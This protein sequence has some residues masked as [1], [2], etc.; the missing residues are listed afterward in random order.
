VELPD[1]ADERRRQLHEDLDALLDAERHDPGAALADVLVR[2]ERLQRSIDGHLLPTVAGFAGSTT[3]ALDGCRSPAAWFV[4]TLG[5][6]RAA[7]GSLRSTAEGA[8]AHPAIV[9]AARAGRVSLGHVRALLAARVAP[10]E[11][12]FDAAVQSLVE[13]AAVRSVDALVAHLERWRLDA[14]EELA[15][16]EPDGAPPEDPTGSTCRVRELLWGRAKVELDLDPIAAAEFTAGID[17]EY[18]ALRRAGAFDEDPRTLRE[19]H[20]EIAMDIWRRGGARHGTAAPSPLVHAIVDLDTLL[21][22]AGEDPGEARTRRIAELA[23]HGPVS[24][25]VIAELAA[26]AEVSLLVTHPATGVPL[27]YGRSRRLASKDQRAAVIASSDGHCGFPG[28][29]VPH[30]RCEVDHRV[31]WVAGGETDI[32]DLLLACP[33]HNRLKHRWNLRVERRSDGTLAWFHPSGAEIRS[34]HETTSGPPRP[35]RGPAP[36]T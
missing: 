12:V 17:Q 8:D 14:L 18:E 2:W 7:A 29:T 9:A 23:G 6:K 26:R 15:R 28:C 36:G 11:E 10:L 30:P 31:G 5:T 34:R 19:I 32:D 25:A 1:D 20:G 21:H 33:F 35:G 24:D 13:D 27:W 22:R 4:A 3:W 16:N